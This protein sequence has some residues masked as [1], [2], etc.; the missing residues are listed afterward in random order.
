MTQV[1]SNRSWQPAT[2]YKKSLNT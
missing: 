2:C 1:D